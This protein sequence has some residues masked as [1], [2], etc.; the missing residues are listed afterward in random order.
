MKALRVPWPDVEPWSII[1]AQDGQTATVLPGETPFDI[2]LRHHQS[3]M[4]YRYARPP[5]GEVTVLEP[6][7]GDAVRDLIAHFTIEEIGTADG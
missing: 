1:Q 2:V 4:Y 7:I 5:A 6:E 3:D